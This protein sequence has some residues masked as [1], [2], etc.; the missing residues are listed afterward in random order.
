VHALALVS[1]ILLGAAFVAAGVFKLR[2]GLAWPKQ[3]GDMGVSYPV[4]V[5]VP[6][7]ELALGV[8]SIVVILLPWSAYAAIGVLIVFT[9][10]ILR[11]LLDGSRPPCAC[12]GSR[13]SRSLGPAHVARN[14]V[15]LVLASVAAFWG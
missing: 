2:D 7:L 1:S 14:V 5:A 12:F 8:A 9:A 6:W 4:A 11:R 3:A 15:L 13:F 10:V